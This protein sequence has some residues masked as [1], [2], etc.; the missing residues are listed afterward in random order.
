M[1]R[2]KKYISK[3]SNSRKQSKKKNLNSNINSKFLEYIQNGGTPDDKFLVFDFFKTFVN[4]DYDNKKKIINIDQYDSILALLKNSLKYTKIYII[5]EYLKS[6]IKDFLGKLCCG[7][8]IID[9]YGADVKNKKDITEDKLI[10]IE[11]TDWSK[12]KVEFLNDICNKNKIIKTD[13]LYFDDNPKYIDEAIKSGYTFSFFV[14]N[15]AK[16]S[17]ESKAIKTQ[18]NIFN[19]NGGIE[20]LKYINKLT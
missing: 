11:G 9:V 15:N 10:S 16:K 14:S 2:T 7:L 17:K 20:L 19:T 13:I 4:Y 3:D 1:S 12:K 6:E 18:T 8:F 5:D